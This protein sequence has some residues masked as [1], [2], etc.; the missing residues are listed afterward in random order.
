LADWKRRF[1]ELRVKAKLGSM[2]MRDKERKWI[3]EFEPAYQEAMKKLAEAQAAAGAE[4]KALRSG[5]EAGWRELRRAYGEA[6]KGGG[7]D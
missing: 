4:A 1:Q 6:R 5:I 2:E 3:E 7:K